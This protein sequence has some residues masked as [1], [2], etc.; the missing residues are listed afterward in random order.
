[1]ASKFDESDFVDSDYQPSH[2]TSYVA[3]TTISSAASHNRPPSREEIEMKVNETQS[4]LAEL[5]RA[6]EELERERAALEEARRRRAEFQAGRQEM[7]DHLTRGVGLLHEAEFAARREAEQMSRT[8]ADLRSALEK[9]DSLREELW[10]EENWNSE[11]T[12]S[13]T[14]LENS[15]MEWNSARLKW[16]LLDQALHATLQKEKEAEGLGFLKPKSFFDLCKLG[17]AMTWPIAL[18]CL[19]GAIA[20]LVALLL[21]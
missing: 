16:P 20:L 17:L 5:K 14:V 6:Q 3:A 1:M 8:L 2:K 4:K 18:V 11:L 9:V 21:K 15:R 12:R 7:L 10:T 13:L 19:L